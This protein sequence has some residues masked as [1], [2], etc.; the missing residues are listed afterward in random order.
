LNAGA[1]IE[2]TES[3][4][5]LRL[6]LVMSWLICCVNC[7]S[8][9]VNG[10]FAIGTPDSDPRTFTP[11]VCYSGDREY[12]LG[13]DLQSKTDPVQV[14]IFQDPI[15]GTFLKVVSDE[16]GQSK[17]MLFEK[18]TCKV[19]TG[20]LKETKWRVNK[21]RDISGEL[22]IDCASGNDGTIKGKITFTHCH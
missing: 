21:I 15:K 22:D 2:Y 18:N 17:E 3:M 5:D 6:I 4:K 19:L 12:F 1:R 7:V 10:S 11:N 13:V 16:T 8:T 9:K 20:E 14:R